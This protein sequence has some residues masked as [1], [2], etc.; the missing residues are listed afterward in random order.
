MVFVLN[1]HNFKYQKLFM[2]HNNANVK[3]ETNKKLIRMAEVG[4]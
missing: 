1:I 4:V 3:K 2:L